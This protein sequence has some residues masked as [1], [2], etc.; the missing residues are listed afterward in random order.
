MRALGFLLALCGFTLVCAWAG[1]LA[2]CGGFFADTPGEGAPPHDLD[3]EHPLFAPLRRTLDSGAA[4]TDQA[5]ADVAAAEDVIP[6]GACV[7][8]GGA[9]H[10]EW[11]SGDQ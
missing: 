5:A 4:A 6:F 2:G 3:T 11:P 1:L 8:D 10:C 9:I 7:R